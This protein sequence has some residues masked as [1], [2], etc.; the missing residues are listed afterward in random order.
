MSASEIPAAA[1][2]NT[3]RAAS[4]RTSGRGWLI[5]ALTPDREIQIIGAGPLEGTTINLGEVD[6]LLA[7]LQNEGGVPANNPKGPAQ[8]DERSP[9]EIKLDA[10]IRKLTGLVK[11]LK[12][13]VKASGTSG[14]LTQNG[15]LSR[16]LSLIIREKVELVCKEKKADVYWFVL[17][18][19][20]IIVD[21]FPPFPDVSASIS[22]NIVIKK[23]EDARKISDWYDV[24]KE[25]ME[26]TKAHYGVVDPT[27]NPIWSQHP[28]FDLFVKNYKPGGRKDI[29][30]QTLSDRY[31]PLEEKIKSIAGA[32]QI[33]RIAMAPEGDSFHPDYNSVVKELLLGKV[34]ALDFWEVMR[35]DKKYESVCRYLS[36]LAMNLGEAC[37][38][39]DIYVPIFEALT[40]AFTHGNKLDFKNPI[41]ISFIYSG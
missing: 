32:S 22:E 41:Y 27:V 29:L 20:R 24:G 11:D 9:E 17:V 35:S 30:S 5:F 36:F 33:A 39:N 19:G 18:G 6:R 2:D 23:I 13:T 16:I 25:D 15:I 4:R 12:I 7:V 8:P 14:C 10:Y 37:G 26:T 1:A 28:V 21:I 3:N 31:A 34:V 38:E 40:N